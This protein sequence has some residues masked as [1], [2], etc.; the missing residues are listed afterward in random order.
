MTWVIAGP[1]RRRYT[2]INPAIG[3]AR[4]PDGPRKGAVSFRG[5]LLTVHP[6]S[7]L[8]PRHARTRQPRMLSGR[9]CA[10][11]VPTCRGA[12]RRLPPTG[13][14]SRRK[15]PSG[16]ERLGSGRG[17]RRLPRAT[18]APGQRRPQGFARAHE[19]LPSGPAPLGTSPSRSAYAAIARFSAHNRTLKCWFANA[20]NAHHS[21]V[22]ATV[23][24]FR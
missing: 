4:W 19:R 16:T 22:P 20:S 12:P 13:R 15:N 6:L 5:G 21:I 14:A 10:I 11:S 7:Q 2:E 23:T 1:G 24:A 17:H 18:P 8:R 3:S 9:R